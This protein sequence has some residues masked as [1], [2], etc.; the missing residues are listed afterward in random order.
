MP[1]I[2]PEYKEQA[3]KRI[4]E[5]ALRIFSENGYHN[6][7]MEDIG[8]KLGVS[9]ATIYNYFKSKEDLFLA[10]AEYRIALRQEQFFS[11]LSTDL[12]ALASEQF[13]LENHAKIA[14][15]PRFSLD[16]INE[17][18]RNELLRRKFRESN[19]LALERLLQFFDS[20]KEKKILKQEADS[21]T[22]IFAFMA[23]RDG[24][25]LGSL[26]GLDLSAAAKAWAKIWEMILKDVTVDPL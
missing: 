2:I 20:F 26:Y 19:D 13:F 22:L 9:K 5:G 10:V 12:N 15:S 25:N 1:R 17:I 4:I 23:I 24:L 7:K 11:F 21:K 6:T 14:D 3:E 16:F 18:R 8:K